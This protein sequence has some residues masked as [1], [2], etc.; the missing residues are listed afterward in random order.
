MPD[1]KSVVGSTGLTVGFLLLRYSGVY[2]HT[3][4]S[5]FVFC[6][7]FRSRFVFTRK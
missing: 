1:V 3:V 4:E 2:T 6:L 5:L 7:L